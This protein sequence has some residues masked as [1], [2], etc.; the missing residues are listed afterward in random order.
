MPDIKIMV[1]QRAAHAWHVIVVHDGEE[2]A[3]SPALLTRT[4]A[5][6]A[7]REVNRRF[8]AMMHE[9]ARAGH[10]FSLTRHF[11]A[12]CCAI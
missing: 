9:R 4:L 11:T 2:I 1:E 8:V 5:W 7:A 3:R 10:P 12:T 6:E